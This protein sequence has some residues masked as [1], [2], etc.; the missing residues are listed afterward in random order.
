[1]SARPRLTAAASQPASV[2]IPR[3]SHVPHVAGHAT[4]SHERIASTTSEYLHEGKEIV[5]AFDEAH[6]ITST[7]KAFDEQH[8][9]TETAS[10]LLSTTIE[11]G[12]AAVETIGDSDLVDAILTE[13]RHVSRS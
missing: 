3:P 7:I 8:Q 5:K 11:T 2:L 1:M 13:V 10:A 6:Q 4:S 9:V 12:K